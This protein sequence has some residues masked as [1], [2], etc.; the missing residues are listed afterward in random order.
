MNC[1]EFLPPGTIL[2]GQYSFK[3]LKY[4]V[5]AEVCSWPFNCAQPIMLS[6]TPHVKF[7]TLKTS[8]GLLY[9]TALYSWPG[10]HLGYQD[11]DQLHPLLSELLYLPSSG[12]S[13]PTEPSSK[14]SGIPFLIA[15]LPSQTT[16]LSTIIQR[17]LR[18]PV[19]P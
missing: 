2:V 15:L 8:F 14:L 12:H 5:S 11:S 1:P 16:H 7:K 3:R 10:P 19:L 13:T 4:S 9:F 17:I 18:S 6:V